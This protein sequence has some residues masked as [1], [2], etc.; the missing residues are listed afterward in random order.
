MKM[1]NVNKQLIFMSVYFFTVAPTYAGAM[2]PIMVPAA[3]PGKVY[4]SFFGGGGKSSS[5]DSSLFGS[6]YYSEPY[7][8]PL[9]VTA[10]GT[11]S[12]KTIGFL[13]GHV[14]YQWPHI[15]FNLF[16]SVSGLTPATE[17][18]GYYVTQTTYSG[19]QTNN[20]S[21]RPSE[22]DFSVSFPMSAGVFLV[23]AIANFDLTSQPAFHPYVGAGIGSGILSI[24]NAVSTQLSPPE[25][26]VN[27]FNSQ[28][29]SHDTA[30]AIQVKAGLSMDL[31]QNLS[32]FGEYRWLYLSHPSFVFGS[33]IYADHPETSSWLASLGSQ[34]YNLGAAGIRYSI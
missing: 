24:T 30:F 6:V 21:L 34:N 15:S 3:A 14:G 27:H 18:E 25:A 23:N 13:G 33:T 20:Q 22:Y 26:G 17:L 2:D 31:T 1:N 12:G 8:G 28:A 5:F 19:N 16:N 9:A 4:A 7:G 10:F 11:T 32:I 29:N